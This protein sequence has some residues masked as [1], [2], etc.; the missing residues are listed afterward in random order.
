MQLHN[1]SRSPSP[2]A[3]KT[4]TNSAS[5]HG[6]VET[7]GVAPDKQHCQVSTIEFEAR[8]NDSSFS[9]DSDFDRN[10]DEMQSDML[11]EQA[12]KGGEAADDKAKKKA[13][14]IHEVIKE[15]RYEES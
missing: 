11:N 6:H 12:H 10:M 13:N 3:N 7:M 1:K 2:R 14:I 5:R 9:S 15:E 4:Y 8:N